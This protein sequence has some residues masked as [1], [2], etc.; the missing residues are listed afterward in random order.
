MV[1]VGVDSGSLQT[2]SRLKS[3]GLVSGSTAT[4][5]R[6]TFLKWT[7]WT[8]TMV[9]APLTSSSSSSSSIHHHLMATSRWTSTYFHHFASSARHISKFIISTLTSCHQVGSSS[10]TYV[11]EPVT[12]DLCTTLVYQVLCFIQ[13]QLLVM[14]GLLCKLMFMWLYNAYT[15]LPWKRT[16]I[17]YQLLMY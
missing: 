6:F 13:T 16:L 15:L 7:G 11:C 3:V 14:D 17:G 1:M 10:S 8:L 12:V 9:I 5:H 4:W 2:D